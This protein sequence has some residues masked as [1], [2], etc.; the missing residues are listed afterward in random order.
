[1]WDGTAFKSR[2]NTLKH[3][4]FAA[5]LLSSAGSPCLRS[6]EGAR[7]LSKSDEKACLAEGHGDVESNTLKQTDPV[8]RALLQ[9]AKL[10]CFSQAL[11][12]F[13]ATCTSHT[14]VSRPCPEGFCT[15][16][17]AHLIVFTAHNFS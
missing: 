5:M 7:W 3:P 4:A 9:H 17:A 1:M 14:H 8:Q 15:K 11:E 10:L 2:S 12:G 6:H 13:E 16:D